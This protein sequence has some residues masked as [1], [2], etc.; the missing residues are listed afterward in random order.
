MTESPHP[1]FWK[2][3]WRGILAIGLCLLAAA[4]LGG[5]LSFSPLGFSYDRVP[6][7]AGAAQTAFEAAALSVLI[8][9]VVKEMIESDYER[10]ERASMLAAADV[11][12]QKALRALFGTFYDDDAVEHIYRT[13][14]SSSLIREDM[15]IEYRLVAHPTSA[16][17]VS[18]TASLRYTIK[19]IGPARAICEPRIV[20]PN[21]AAIFRDD[22]GLQVPRLESAQVGTHVFSSRE[23]A[24]L[25]AMAAREDHEIQFPLGAH[26]IKPEGSLWVSA[27]YVRDK[28]IC[29]SELMRMHFPTKKV[30]L[31]VRN[32]LA[33]DLE[34]QVKE[35]GQQGF[36][37]RPTDAAV[38]AWTCSHEGIL[39][40]NNGWVLYW[41]DPKL[42]PSKIP[43]AR[44]TEAERAEAPAIPAPPIER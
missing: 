34:M 39:L 8:A 18:F 32:E 23:L 33:P 11:S 22:G 9:L 38:P 3:I 15:T 44:H 36:S 2:R 14:F 31:S 6:G 35:I 28:L 10:R 19:N 20:V 1:S 7:L 13:I 43:G 24:D 40:E 4:I 12:R 16:W 30:T 5:S 21:Y 25:N 29:D 27:S 41:N 42:E 17:L 26:A 37:D